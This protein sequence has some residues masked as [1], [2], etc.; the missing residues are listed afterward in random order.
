MARKYYVAVRTGK[1]N[2]VLKF[3]TL[4]EARHT[5]AVFR[6]IG[7]TTAVGKPAPTKKPAKKRRAKKRSFWS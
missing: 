4:K 2:Q 3:S 1:K 6:S 7:Y 5:A